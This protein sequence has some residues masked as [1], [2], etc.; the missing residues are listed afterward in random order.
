MSGED[1]TGIGSYAQGHGDHTVALGARSGAGAWNVAGRYADVAAYLANEEPSRYGRRYTVV[2]DKIYAIAELESIWASQKDTM[3][4]TALAEASEVMSPTASYVALTD[5]LNDSS[6]IDHTQVYIGE[7]VYKVAELEA[8]WS[9]LTDTILPIALADASEVIATIAFYD[10]V[11]NYLEDDD[12][13][14]SSQVYI[15]GKVYNVADL[16]A[17]EGLT[18][19]T[20]PNPLKGAVGAIAVGV[21]AHATRERAVAIGLDAHALGLQSTALGGN[22]QATSPHTTAVGQS[23]H[24]TGDRATAIGQSAEATEIESTAVG[25]SALAIGERA[26]ATGQNARAYFDDSTA[27]GHDAHAIGEESTVLG[28]NAVSVGEQNTVLGRNAV[29]VAQDRSNSAEARSITECV[30]LLESS[31][32]RDEVLGGCGEY[33]TSE[34]QQDSRL[35]QDGTAGDT[36]RET[37]GDRLFERLENLVVERATAVGRDARALAERAT[38]V[39]D[40]SW[41][42]GYRSTALG[43]SSRALGDRSTALG[44]YASADGERSTV[45]GQNSRTRGERNTAVGTGAVAAT[46]S[47]VDLRELWSCTSYPWVSAD[48]DRFAQY[49]AEFFTADE[50]QDPRLTQDDA[51]GETFRETIRMRLQDELDDLAVERSVAVGVSAKA[52]NDRATAVG[53]YARATGFRS[54]A[55]GEGALATGDSSTAVGAWGTRAAGVAGTAVGR[56]AQESGIRNT[57]IGAAANTHG[58]EGVAVGALSGAGSW[59]VWRHYPD[60]AAYLADNDRVEFGHLYLV[61]GGKVYSSAELEAMGSSLTDA[62]LPS[63][64]ADA[65]EIVY[66]NY[67]YTSVEEYLDNPNRTDHGQVIIGEKVYSVTDLEAAE[68]LT[69][70]SLPPPLSGASGTVAIGVRAHATAEN[71][72]ALGLDAHAVGANAVAIGSGVTAAADEV[73]IGLATHAYRL[74]GVAA[75]QTDNPEVLTVDNTGRLSSDGGALHQR[76]QELET[77]VQELDQQVQAFETSAGTTD[78]SGD[79]VDVLPGPPSNAVKEEGSMVAQITKAKQ[80]PES[81]NAVVQQLETTTPTTGYDRANRQ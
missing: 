12:R 6:R 26:T 66:P 1:G 2:A 44:G 70:D 46:D 36:F 24:A 67:S 79:I 49:C 38:A 60:V 39:G 34:E 27:V 4:A 51:D 64:L 77:E 16:E 30:L 55:L 68:N 31:G 54:T 72:V 71:A 42:T 59:T 56:F 9:S 17:V 47:S 8:I 40:Y 29:A 5:Y 63:P 80:D 81:T 23:A 48:P 14:R 32:S 69:E 43:V 58:R 10:S 65:S 75:L 62:N 18:E 53:A 3:L 15:D 7:D 50:Q 76:V 35:G 57:S 21:G 13:T 52:L 11:E 25:Q 33:L 61:I 19:D 74:P 45:V 37:I 28:Q 22:S 73:V 41:A 20:L 78:G